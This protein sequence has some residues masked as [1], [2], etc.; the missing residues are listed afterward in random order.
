MVSEFLAYLEPTISLA[1][2]RRYQS[3][4]GDD[5]ETAVNYLW[6]MALSESLYCCLNAVEIALRNGLHD[7]LTAHFGTPAWYDQK[8]L[9]ERKQVEDVIAVK[10]RVRR[11]GESVTPDRVVSEL[12][13]GFWV[14]IL[15]RNYNARLWQGQ[16]PA[17]LRHAFPRTPKRQRQ[18]QPIHQHFNAI[19]ELRNRVFHHEPLFDDQNLRWRHSEVYQGLGWINPKLLAWIKVVDRFPHV[20]SRGR[21]D[22]ETALKRHL[23]I[24]RLKEET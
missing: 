10:K 16:N 9:L 18:R 21:R 14:T 22:A 3:A 12:N 1:R 23:N 19:R 6:N 15:S 5:L 4:T 13:F 20:Y 11:D 24:G 8:G 7:T 2:L 17:Q